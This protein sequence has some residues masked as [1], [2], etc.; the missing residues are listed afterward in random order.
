MPNLESISVNNG[1]VENLPGDHTGGRSP[2]TVHKACY[3]L[4]NPEPVA[5]PTLVAWS[6]DM[7]ERFDLQRP[8]SGD[9][10]LQILAGNKVTAAM[11]P[12][13]ACYG[14]HQFGGWARQLGDGRAIVLGELNDRRDQTWELQLKGAGRTPYSRFAD[15]R[16]VLRSSLREFIASEAMYHL[17][18]PTTRALSLLLTGDKVE[19]DMFYDGSPQDEPGAICARM[20]PSFLR[21]GNFEIHAANEN[22]ELLKRLADWTITHHFNKI[23]L[24]SPTAY[25][26]WFKQI[27]V[28][29]AQLMV[30]WL[31]VGF[32]HGVMN[33]DNM[34]VLGLTIDYGPFG[35]LDSY[36]PSWTPNTT[37]LPGR[38]YCYGQQGSIGLWNLE[39]LAHALGPLFTNADPLNEGLA[40]YAGAYEKAF[41]KM[42]AGK[43]GLRNIDGAEDLKL[44]TDLDQLLQDT[45]TDMTMFFR[46]LSAESIVPAVS[47]AFYSTPTGAHLENISAW[48]DRLH[49]RRAADNM[50]SH[51]RLNLMNQMNPRIIPRNYLLYKVIEDVEKGDLTSLE[52][53]YAALRKPY[54]DIP[55]FDSLTAKRPDWA[56]DTPGSSTLSC[57]S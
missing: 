36:D 2:R 16:A 9:N 56:R 14:G 34:S 42:M 18:V 8:S 4:V 17:G 47:Q 32:V 31:R 11:K 21:F 13:A 44:I 3:S 46:G 20:A 49:T 10:D 30:E 22:P 40:A 7:A 37:D 51:D 39:R 52:R 29:T 33:T 54:D 35:F 1:F 50:N 45:E 53:L 6:D 26:D 28:S 27:C 25:A 43:L 57:S 38:R 15:G 48:L 23:D 12:Y 55:E 19:R 41:A 5:S 24:T